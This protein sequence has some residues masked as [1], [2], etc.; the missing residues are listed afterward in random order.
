MARSLTPSNLY[1]EFDMTDRNIEELTIS[2]NNAKNHCYIE[3]NKGQMYDTFIVAK[4]KKVRTVCKTFIRKST[5][6]KKYVLSIEFRK[7]NIEGESAVSRGS[8]II[9]PF[10]ESEELSSF[11][12]LIS[13]FQKFNELIDTGDFSNRYQAITGESLK[14]YY[15]KSVA[16]DKLSALLELVSN[17]EL[18]E[19]H[20]K[21][22]IFNQRKKDLYGFY[23]LL[24]NEESED[25]LAHDRYRKKFDIKERGSEVIW[26]HFLKENKW[27]LGLNT[28]L[29]FIYDLHSEHKLGEENSKGAGSSKTDLLGT[30]YFTTIIELKTESTPI[31]KEN[32]SNK[33]RANTW[34]FSIDFIEAYSQTLGQNDD[35]QKNRKKRIEMKD[36]SALDRELIRTLDPKCLLIIGSR[37][38]EFPHTNTRD[39]NLKTDSF[40]RFRRDSKKV[41]IITYDELFERAFHIINQENLSMNWFDIPSS[42]FISNYLGNQNYSSLS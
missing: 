11:W 39:N 14:D 29:R 24:K 26:H 13:F 10:K 42:E 27:I 17:E 2:E 23:L 8:S 20:L 1:I 5:S 30:S 31:F 35:L 18:N 6:K 15:T 12:T 21:S 3:D 32:K 19:G 16:T 33:S 41:D 4:K 25:G 28:E 36:G 38:K 7:E 34:D 40:E 22:I 9:V 37:N